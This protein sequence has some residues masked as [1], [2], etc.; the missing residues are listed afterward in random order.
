MISSLKLSDVRTVDQVSVKNFYN[1]NREAL[2]L[3]LVSSPK[4][5]SRPIT[6]PFLNRPGLALSGFYEHF[7]HRRIQVFGAAEEAY[8]RSLSEEVRRTRL[9]E[10]LQGDTPCIIYAR[11]IDVP[12]EALELADKYSVCVFQTELVTMKFVNAA[13]IILENA[14]AESTTVYG[15]MVDI[16]GMGV[17]LIGESGIGKSEAAL[18]LVEH[19]AAS[20][21]AD[22]IVR[23]RHI[24]GDLIAS[25]PEMSY[26]FLEVRG[27]GV[28][29]VVTLFGLNAFRKEK[30]VDLMIILKAGLS[31]EMDRLGLEREPIDL[32]GVKIPHVELPVAPGRDTSRLVE[33][34]AMEHSMRTEGFDMAGEFNRRLHQRYSE[35][36]KLS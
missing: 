22:D 27:L 3:R 19:G 33:V 25:A 23:L 32:M 7:E 29:N 17:L 6:E 8:M 26:G 2:R 12:R 10:L 9:E 15:C 18:G 13:T 4:G 21:V 16:R 1:S 36:K 28:V 35:G 34:A 24:G 20:L 31:S 14:F 5:F 30:K 11:G